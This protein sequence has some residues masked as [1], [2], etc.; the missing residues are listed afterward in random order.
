LDE[1]LAKKVKSINDI[2]QMYK[3]SSEKRGFNAL[4]YGDIGTGKT[5]LAETCRKPV[6]V[7]SFDPNG[8]MVLRDSIEEGWLIADNRFEAEDPKSPSAF[9]NWDQ[10]YHRLKKEGMFEIFGTYFIDSLTTLSQIVMSFVLGKNGRA[11]GI[12]EAGAGKSSD[13][14]LQMNY[15]EIT[16]RDFFTLPCDVILTAHPDVSKDEVTGKQFIGPMVTGQLKTRLPL[17]FDEL[18]YLLTSKDAKGEIK[19]ALLTQPD[20]SA[21]AKTRLGMKGRFNTF[22]EPDIRGLLKKSGL[23]FADKP[24]PWLQGA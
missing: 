18:Y 9:R 13:Y 20:G 5:T 17:L 8:T 19:R 24:I 10:E 2:R 22:E 1:I 12:P 16:I 7:H 3:E 4:I 21:K 15:L 14:V 23:P 11:G 6:L